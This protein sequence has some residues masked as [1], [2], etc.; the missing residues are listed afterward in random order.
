M[1]RTGLI[2]LGIFIMLLGNAAYA[3][4]LGTQTGGWDTDMGAYT[5]FHNVVFQWKF[6]HD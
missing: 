4:V 5:Y 2:I 6:F 1:K 3:D